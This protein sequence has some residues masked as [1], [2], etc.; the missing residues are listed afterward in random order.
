M[1][2]TSP[3]RSIQPDK[4][5]KGQPPHTEDVSP[6]TSVPAQAVPSVVE[7]ATDGSL[8]I[9]GAQA[10]RLG[11]AQFPQT[12]MPT[13]E[14]ARN[15]LAPFGHGDIDV[16]EVHGGEQASFLSVAESR[17]FLRNHGSAI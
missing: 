17:P 16:G 7:V 4:F 15:L 13:I 9:L 3:M 11:P 6:P 5:R 8:E 10:K 1:H 2:L 14:L 12:Q